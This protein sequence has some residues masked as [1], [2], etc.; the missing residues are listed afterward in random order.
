MYDIIS[1]QYLENYKIKLTFED[2]KSGIVDFPYYLQ[3]DGVFK[4]FN[5]ISYF[6]SFRFDP[7]I[8]HIPW[9]NEIDIAPEVLYSEATRTPL[10][11]WMEDK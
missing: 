7:E 5:D 4:K 1:A 10:H 2:G 3:Q 9:N 11:Q 8:G 6:K